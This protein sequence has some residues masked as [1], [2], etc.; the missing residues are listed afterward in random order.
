MSIQSE[1]TRITNK[2]DASFTA[3]ANKG[4]V[5]PV[6]ST[7]DDLPDLIVAIPTGASVYTVSASY[8]NVT[9]STNDDEVLQGG[10]F[11]ADLTPAAGYKI[12]NISVMM[13]GVD[14]TSQAFTPGTGTKSIIANGT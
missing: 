2:R 3:V 11:F 8:S 10:S 13:G 1:I 6:G 4:V 9:S 14:V 5:V 12:T 7:L